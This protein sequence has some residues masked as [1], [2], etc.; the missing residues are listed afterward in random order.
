[1]TAQT[2]PE[3]LLKPGEVAAYLRVDPKTVSRWAASGRL[4]SVRTPG[5]HRRYRRADV[6]AANGRSLNDL[7]VKALH[8]AQRVAFTHEGDVFTVVAWCG[9]QAYTG[10]AET[11][12]EALSL[13]MRQ[14]S[15]ARAQA[16][17]TDQTKSEDR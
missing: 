7:L 15:A 9:E 5:G 2:S 6:E 3:D 4:P 10:S 16:D 8:T 14:L 13:A 12:A 17:A 11:P 1:M